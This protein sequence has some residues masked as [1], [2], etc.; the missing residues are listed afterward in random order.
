MIEHDDPRLGLDRRYKALKHANSV[1]QAAFMMNSRERISYIRELH[2]YEL[3]SLNQLAK[4]CRVSVATV[5]RKFPSN[6]GGGR[7]DPQTLT[8]L[9]QIR[10]A[11]LSRDQL[12]RYM[13]RQC[14][15]HGTSLGTIARLTGT[16]RPTLYRVYNS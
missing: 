12:H 3:F 4:I 1:W 10:R 15:E 14:V 13:I 2:E 9:M 7:F 11:V 16:S 6:A 5:S 8:S